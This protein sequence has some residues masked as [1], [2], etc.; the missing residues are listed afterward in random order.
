LSIVAEQIQKDWKENYCYEPVLLETFVDLEHFKGTCYKAAN[1]INIGETKGRGRMDRYSK[2]ELSRK[3]I[4]M[5]PLEKNFRE[6]LKGEIPHKRLS[7]DD[8]WW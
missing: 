6:Y 5:Y 2:R 8:M 1:W 4:F 3:G 7:E